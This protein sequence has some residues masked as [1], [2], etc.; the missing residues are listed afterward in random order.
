M[1][2]DKRLLSLDKLA[3]WIL[4]LDYR[5][6][7]WHAQFYPGHTVIASGIEEIVKRLQRHVMNEI[8][9]LA[10]DALKT[11]PGKIQVRT[12]AREV[13]DK[14]IAI[15]NVLLQHFDHIIPYTEMAELLGW[16]NHCMIIHSRNNA[17]VKEIQHKIQS[18]YKRFPFLADGFKTLR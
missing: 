14:R 6:N 10:C 9:E 16:R 13:V 5:E 8:T 2:V 15:A 3:P 1:A 12:R 11:T 18:I 17:D 4:K 7:Q